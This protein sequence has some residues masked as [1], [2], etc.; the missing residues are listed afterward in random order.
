MKKAGR[1]DRHVP[2]SCPRVADFD[3]LDLGRSR[4]CLDF[5][6]DVGRGS[7]NAT[8]MS[9]QAELVYPPMLY[10]GCFYPRLETASR[11]DQ[12]LSENCRCNI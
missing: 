6:E 11:E 5:D 10:S 1:S 4:R 12:L 8:S 2:H 7:L 3:T 9:R